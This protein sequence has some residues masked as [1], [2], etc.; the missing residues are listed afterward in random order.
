MAQSRAQEEGL[1]ERVK[2]AL[3]DY[4]QHTGCYD[5]IVSV[6]MFEHVG[7]PYYEAYFSKLRDLLAEDGVVLLHTIGRSGVPA[8]TN[9][10]I[11]K[12][13]FP[14]GYIPALS[15]MMVAIEKA[16]LLVNDIE[17]LRYH[18]ADTLAA[19][20][21][22]FNAHRDEFVDSKGETFCRM[23][24][25]YLAMCEAAFRS[26]DLVVYQV[27]LSKSKSVVADTRDY[28]YQTP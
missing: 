11:Q 20:G 28:L 13:I 7:R 23:W 24:E 4:R 1:A 15:E 18:Y 2:F 14:G 19:W 16:G 12:Y 22:R 21:E 9:P 26:S 27:Q 8:I 17:I 10:W 5:R 25:I 3:Q 6:G